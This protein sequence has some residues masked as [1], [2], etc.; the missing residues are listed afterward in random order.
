MIQEWKQKSKQLEHND[1][2]YDTGTPY[3]FHEQFPQEDGIPKLNLKE[4]KL[5]R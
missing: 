4:G 5:T 3:S 2:L 1:I